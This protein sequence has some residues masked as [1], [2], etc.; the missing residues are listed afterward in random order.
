M[1]EAIA[2]APRRQR[3]GDQAYDKIK[4]DIIACRLWPGSE[5]TEAGLAE[6]YSLG[7]APIRAALS[8]LTQEGLVNVV[9]RRGYVIAPITSQSVQ[10]IFQLRLLLEPAAAA[11][12]AGRVDVAKLKKMS[13]GPYDGRGTAGNLQFLKDNR[14]FHIE[15][16]RASGNERLERILASILD[17]MAR[18]LH[19]G[20]FAGADAQTLSLDHKLQRRQHAALVEALANGDRKGA[21]SIARQHI[22][23]SREM[24]VNAVARGAF[25][26]RL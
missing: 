3:L 6:H 15:I 4:H 12:A 14:D 8:R 1:L 21:E 11:A 10:E 2:S 23:H 18:L 7:L 25:S 19:L 24:V 20:L 9:P 16:A 17:E 13:A 22:E 26:V 5:A